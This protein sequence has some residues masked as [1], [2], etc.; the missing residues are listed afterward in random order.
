[1]F[2]DYMDTNLLVVGQ[3]VCLR[4]WRECELI[5]LHLKTFLTLKVA[6]RLIELTQ[7]NQIGYGW[8]LEY[9]YVAFACNTSRFSLI[10]YSEVWVSK[11]ISIK[12]SRKSSLC[13]HLLILFPPWGYYW[14]QVL[15]TIILFIFCLFFLIDMFYLMFIILIFVA[16]KQGHLDVELGRVRKL[17]SKFRILS[18]CQSLIDER[19]NCSFLYWRKEMLSIWLSMVYGDACKLCWI[20]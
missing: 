9:G 18:N 14:I 16:T 6:W 1:M 13:T 7:I 12:S 19:T 8:E 20:Q 5:K 17:I 10:L 3:L 11:L 2:R 15:L 4:A